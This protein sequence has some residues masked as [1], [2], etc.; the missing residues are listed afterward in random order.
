M[1]ADVQ[2]QKQLLVYDFLHTTD[3]KESKN[4]QST[5]IFSLKV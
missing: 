4:V 5:E 3:P 1:L 2:K